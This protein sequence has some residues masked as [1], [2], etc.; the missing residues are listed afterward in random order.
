MNLRKP[1][2]GQTL[3]KVS[4]W[5]KQGTPAGHP[6]MAGVGWCQ[7]GKLRNFRE[8]NDDSHLPNTPIN[9]Y[10]I[11]YKS[12]QVHTSPTLRAKILTLHCMGIVAEEMQGKACTTFSLV[13]WKL[14]DQSY[15][16]PRIMAAPDSHE[17]AGLRPPFLHHIFPRSP[18]Q[19][20]HGNSHHNKHPG[21]M[22]LKNI[23]QYPVAKALHLHCQLLPTS[24]LG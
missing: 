21:T 11:S 13:D 20:N 24:I 17:L 1:R 23:A 4:L 3:Q 2:R 8:S 22:V 5:K 16:N 14:T 15:Q 12:I 7:L 9:T 19:T 18:W 6:Q 10:K